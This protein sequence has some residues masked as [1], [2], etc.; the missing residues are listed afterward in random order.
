MIQIKGPK[1]T[2]IR[3]NNEVALIRVCVE[4]HERVY[5]LKRFKMQDARQG[6]STPLDKISLR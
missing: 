5:G 2:G 4:L 3:E 1:E 6:L